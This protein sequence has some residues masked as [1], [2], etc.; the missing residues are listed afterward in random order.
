MNVMAEGEKYLYLRR[1]YSLEASG[2]RRSGMSL[3]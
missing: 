2:R 1:D 3:D